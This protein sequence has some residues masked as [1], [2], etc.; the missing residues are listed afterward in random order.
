M[1]WNAN[2]KL[3]CLLLILG[4]AAIA[5]PSSVYGRHLKK[6]DVS[7]LVEKCEVARETKLAPLRKQAIDECIASG[8]KNEAGCKRYYRDYGNPVARATGTTPRLF[9][10]LPECKISGEAEKHYRLY[11]R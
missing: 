2:P 7:A 4:Y 6:S 8:S 1:K 3:H 11:P 10:D 5:L 9:H